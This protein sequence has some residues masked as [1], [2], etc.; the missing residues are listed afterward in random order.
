MSK[1]I[2]FA[3]SALVACTALA[4][5]DA[6]HGLKDDL[7]FFADFDRPARL[8]GCAFTDPI[9]GGAAAEGRFGSGY[10]FV[11]DERRCEEM[12]WVVRDPLLLTGFPSKRGT[13]ACWCRTPPD[14]MNAGYAPGFGYCGFWKL[15]WFWRGDAFRVG[16]GPKDILSFKGW[17]R[18]ADWHHCAAT[19]NG[20]RLTLFLD[21]KTVGFSDQTAPFDM[22]AAEKPVFRIGAGYEGSPAAN[23]VMDEIAI[24]SRDLTADEIARLANAKKGLLDGDDSVLCD[25]VVF[26]YFWR[27]QE[28]AALRTTFRSSSAVEAR[29]CARIGGRTVA[30]EKISIRKG[31]TPC[32]IA[33][34]PSVLRAGSYPWTLELVAADGRTL[35]SKSGTLQILPRRDRDEFKFFSWGGWRVPPADYLRQVGV[36]SLNVNVDARDQV[37]RYVLEG[38]FPNV[39]YEVFRRDKWADRDCQPS[40]IAAKAER[41][42]DYLKGL[43]VW[44][45]TLVN[46]EVYGSRYP[47]NAT[48]HPA[49][50]ARAERELG[51]KPDFNYRNAPIELNRKS[52]GGTLP[53]GI[54]KRGDCPQLDSLDWVMRMGMAPYPVNRAAATGIH[55]VDGDNTVWSEPIFEGIAADLDMVASWQYDYGT[56]VVLWHMRNQYSVCRA[57]GKPFQPTLDGAYYVEV[58]GTHPT[59]TGKDG[60]PLKVEMPQSLDEIVARSWISLGAVPAHSLAFFY[61]DAWYKGEQDGIV[62]PGTFARFGDIWRSRLAPAA[63]L[64][65]DLA[66]ER[67]PVAVVLPEEGLYASGLDWGQFHYPLA[68]GEGL[69]RYGV[70]YDAVHGRELESGAVARYKLALLPMAR[71]LYRDHAAKLD[72]AAAAGCRIVTGPRAAKTFAGGI[73]RPS[74]DYTGKKQPVFDELASWY[75]EQADRLRT[76]LTAWSDRDTDDSYTF[77]K[78]RDGVRYV[79]VVNDARSTDRGF[80]GKF[81]TN[82]WFRTIGSP[83]RIT[84]HFKVPKGGQVYEFNGKEGFKVSGFKGFRVHGAQECSVACDYA[85]AEGRVFCVYPKALKKLSV[86]REGEALEVSLVDV[87]GKSAP[88]RQVVEVEVRDP[89]GALH[90]E[91]GR[92]VMEGGRLSVP[93]RFAG[94]DPKGSLFKRWKVHAR[95][96]T[97][98]LTVTEGFSR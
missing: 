45:T 8:D 6:A 46:S 88:G 2:Y 67:A 30:E 62:E 15:H 86:S 37:R 55:R 16:P 5:A 87:D 13:F 10:A 72:E 44:K 12:F 19:W 97:S 94:D 81:V 75:P 18:S 79:V 68:L 26:P 22:T 25:P 59:K 76:E 54:L 36:N 4:H 69:R 3:L 84:T 48:N 50:W 58:W 28:N 14:R 92:Y 40:A 89:S 90:D 31:E 80:Y 85:P 78:E 70:P 93:L 42:F 35:L 65:R 1:E 53:T 47:Q 96:L 49:F 91:T 32:A 66:N 82:D 74:F 51:F 33:F 57:Y 61:V 71:V 9:R 34:D 23:L 29:L 27:N 77:L 39:R 43:H 60:K 41:E 17:A 20:N 63:D 7:W 64:L 56:P 38:F 21:G 11:S 98:G 95:E 24:F 73:S 83:Q 52:L